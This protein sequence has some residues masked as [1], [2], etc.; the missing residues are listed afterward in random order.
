[1]LATSHQ[2][3][4]DAK[5]QKLISPKAR[6]SIGSG[7]VGRTLGIGVAGARALSLEIKADNFRYF[8]YDYIPMQINGG[9]G[10]EKIEV[11]FTDNTKKYVYPLMFTYLEGRLID[12]SG[13]TRSFESGPLEP[14]H[15]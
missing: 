13:W 8:I 15:K 7:D 4:T 10:T 14:I 12:V 6:F 9:C 2:A 3:E 11:E 5:L 1:M